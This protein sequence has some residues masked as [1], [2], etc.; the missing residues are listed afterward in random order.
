MDFKTLKK[1]CETKE[2]VKLVDLQLKKK[3]I[4]TGLSRKNTSVGVAVLA[5]INGEFATWLPKRFLDTF[6]EEAVEDFNRN[7]K[8]SMFLEVKELRQ[9]MGRTC[10]IINIDKCE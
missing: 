2:I 10:A 9:I 8:G 3:Y 4:I 6:T 1:C 7:Y 5:D